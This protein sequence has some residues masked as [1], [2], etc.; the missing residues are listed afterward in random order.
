MAPRGRVRQR[1]DHQPSWSTFSTSWRASMEQLQ[2]DLG[3]WGADYN[4][5][6]PHQGRWCYG[7]TPM[8]AFVDTVPL[9]KG[10]MLDA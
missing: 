4:E 1:V 8:Q 7:K 9:A 10:K 3:A 2:A 5:K 6:R